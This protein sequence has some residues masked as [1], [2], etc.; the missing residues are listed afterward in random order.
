MIWL[1]VAVLVILGAGSLV[2]VRRI[3]SW[4][5]KA[6][7][8]IGRQEDELR[9]E[10]R[11]ARERQAELQAELDQ[12]RAEV[13]RA[14]WELEEATA[15]PPPEDPGAAPEKKRHAKQIRDQAMADWLL[16]QG[17]IKLEQHEKA[18]KLVGQLGQ[19]M[20][21]TCLLLD[22]IDKRTA[23]E[24]RKAGERAA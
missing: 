9:E 5:E 4:R 24:A 3:T 2:G 18:S 23:S 13:A 11:Q 21:E 14:R 1:T 6:M 20:A 22:Y 16:R 10:Y 15:E 12:A 17:H 8:D 19:D 7:D